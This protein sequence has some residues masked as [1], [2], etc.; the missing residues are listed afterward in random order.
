MGRVCAPPAKALAKPDEKVY[1]F[2]VDGAPDPYD[3]EAYLWSNG[4]SWI[5]PDGKTTKGFLNSPETAQVFQ[6]FVD[7]VNVG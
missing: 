5:S 4:S 6:M 1:G 7:M 3:F 2:G